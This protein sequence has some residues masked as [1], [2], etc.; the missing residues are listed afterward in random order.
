MKPHGVRK[1]YFRDRYEAGEILAARLRFL[2]DRPLVVLAIP[3]GGVLVADAVAEVLGA[4]LTLVIPRK[5][6][7]PGNPELAIGAVAGEGSLLINEEVVRQLAVPRQYILEEAVREMGEIDRRRRQYGVPD[8]V[9]L[10]G[11]VALIVDDGLATGFTARAAVAAV[12][13]MRPS[14]VILAVPVAPQETVARLREE[15]DRV[16][17]LSTPVEFWAVGQFYA[18]FRQVTDGEVREVLSRHPKPVA[19]A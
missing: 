12:R 11:K 6:G 19:P 2:E 7:A 3:R 4:E 15:A 17:V 18:D 8:E 10:E 5:I 16:V 13:E 1:M 14:E 9:V